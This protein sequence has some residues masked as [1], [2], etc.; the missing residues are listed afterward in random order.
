MKCKRVLSLLL[1][2]AMLTALLILPAGAAQ[3]GGGF[4]DI[5][6]SAVAEA[7]EALR[8]MGVVNGTGGSAFTPGGTLTRAE[9]GKMAVLCMGLADEVAAYETR[10]IFS[11][12]KNHWAK[13]YV[14]LAAS[15]SVT[16]GGNRL[17]AGVGDGTFRPDRVITYGEAVTILLRVLGYTAEADRSW[18]HGAV[19]TAKSIGLADG[20]PVLNA[21]STITRGQAALLF[22]NLLLSETKGGGMYVS[23]IASATEDTVLLSV[24]DEGVTTTASDTALKPV[25]SLPS[26]VLVGRRGVTVLEKKSGKFLTFLPDK[27]TRATVT[28]TANATAK[29]ITA[30]SV[31]YSVAKD[32]MVWNGVSQLAYSSAFSSIT[33]GKTLTLYFDEGG[34]VTYIYLGSGLSGSAM[35]AKNKVTGNPFTSLTGGVT[36]Y[37]IYKNGIPATVDDIRQYDVAVYDSASNALRVSDLRITG[38]IENVS[39]NLQTPETVTVLGHTFTVLDSAVTDFSSFKIGG[40][41]TLLLTENAEV[42]GAVSSDTV[43]GTAVGMFD[44]SA[45]TITLLDSGLVLKPEG[46]SGSV[47]KLD[48]Q[49]VN[50]S[51]YQKGKVSLT[52]VSGSGASGALNVAR[53]TVGNTALSINAK[54]Y[55]RVGDGALKQIS[56]DD[57][58]QASIPASQI[59]FIHRNYAGQIDVLVLSDATGDGYTYGMLSI[60]T[61]ITGSFD[62]EDIEN[63]YISVTNAGQGQ[64]VS[65]VPCG[66]ALSD[67]RMVGVALRA[68]GKVASVKTLESVKNAAR[69]HFDAA[70]MTF[71]TSDMILPI[72]DEVQCYLSSTGEWL[73]ADELSRALGFSEK[74]TVYYDRAPEQGGK[75]RIIVAE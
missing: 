23:T 72:S 35:V 40:S 44:Q 49:L 8:L 47:D 42:A 73:S 13:G 46:Y 55:D 27:S 37:S 43:R 18:P 24:K 4:T 67:G 75:V 60:T 65:S 22:R 71:T 61:Q 5:T 3:T 54:L 29:A 39:P 28:A 14:N 15:Y 12:V 50:V 63:S 69:S 2:A 7:A 36:G 62:G 57:L 25:N 56:L 34:S 9:F 64:S 52:K 1:S 33:A 41:V 17:I 21:S 59:D 30:G 70:A 66:Y 32:V 31:T 74:F 68:S 51:S 10:T 20:L 45:G 16:E 19:A 58:V 6:D 53:A 38:V 48:G 11:D 26:S